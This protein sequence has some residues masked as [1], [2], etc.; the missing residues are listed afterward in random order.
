M[1]DNRPTEIIPTVWAL[2]DPQ[3]GCCLR[4]T[5]TNA[6][7]YAATDILYA[8]NSDGDTLVGSCPV[9]LYNT[10]GYFE[11]CGLTEGV[12][13]SSYVKASSDNV[14]FSAASNISAETPT[15]SAAPDAPVYVSAVPGDGEIVITAQ[16]AADVTIYARAWNSTAGMLDDV[17]TTAGLGVGTDATLTVDG[18]D[19]AKPYRLWIYSYKS[20]YTS[21]WVFLGSFLT[22]RSTGDVTYELLANTVR[23]K[24]AED[25]ATAY[26]IPT[27]YDNQDPGSFAKPTSGVWCRMAILPV[28]TKRMT[29]GGIQNRYRKTG[30]AKISMFT[31]A[32]SGDK[33]QQQTADYIFDAF[34]DTSEGTIVFKAPELSVAQRDGEWW[35]QT[36]NISFFADEFGE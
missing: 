32:G 34:R 30:I 19:N 13:I 2:S 28:Q 3:D 27:Q 17:W 36:I 33:L 5:I 16:A 14:I 12:E 9:S 6:V 22:P 29:I 26:S 7:S 1:S 4:G 15:T 18:L 23:A 21:E 24:F 20:A 35:V 10:L 31:P 11:I 25:V 8:Y